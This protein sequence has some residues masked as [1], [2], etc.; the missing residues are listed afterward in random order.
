MDK[1]RLGLRLI[2]LVIAIIGFVGIAGLWAA[3]Y[4]NPHLPNFLIGTEGWAFL[5]DKL[6]GAAVTFIGLLLIAKA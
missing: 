6:I 5:A 3:P 4:V 2:G 1:S